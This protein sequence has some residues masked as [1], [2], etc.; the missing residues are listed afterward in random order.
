LYFCFY[1][2]FYNYSLGYN[3]LFSQ[4]AKEGIFLNVITAVAYLTVFRFLG[5]ISS[6][7]FSLYKWLMKKI[8]KS[9]PHLDC[10]NCQ[11]SVINLVNQKLGINLEFQKDKKQIFLIVRNYLSLKH[12]ELASRSYKQGALRQLRRN[13]IPSL[14]ILMI[15]IMIKFN[16]G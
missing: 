10:S 4:Q 2:F 13:C 11:S 3:N 9:N 6:S 1:L 7:L 12:P 14:Y 5:I 15:C 8:F 16:Y